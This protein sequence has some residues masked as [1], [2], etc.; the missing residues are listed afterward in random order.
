MLE[1]RYSQLAGPTALW[2]K[3]MAEREDISS[4]DVQRSWIKLLP[5]ICSFKA[6]KGDWLFY[7]NGAGG[8]TF[9]SLGGGLNMPFRGENAA[10]STKTKPASSSAYCPA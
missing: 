4:K 8:E 5:E 9:A 6:F 2:T 1:S 10:W 3:A 7:L